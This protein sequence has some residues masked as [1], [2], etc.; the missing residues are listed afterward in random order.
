MNANDLENII[1][2]IEGNTLTLKQILKKYNITYY[3]YRQITKEYE[4]KKKPYVSET[5]GE[6]K[7]RPKPTIF[8]QLLNP[9]QTPDEPDQTF[10]LEAFKKDCQ[11]GMKF[12][13]LMDKHHLSLYQLRELRKR[14]ELKTK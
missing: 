6:F 8:R 10:D 2:D 11:D 12:S 4:L 9:H 14:Y 13:E 1:R 3:K 7:K 5:S